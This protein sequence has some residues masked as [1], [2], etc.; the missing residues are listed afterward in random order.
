MSA[1]IRAGETAV[2]AATREAG[3]SLKAAWRAHITGAGLGRQLANTIRSE[4]FP[5]GR[6]RLNAAALVWS[7]APVIVGAHVAGPLIRSRNGYWLAIPTPAAG[8][9]SRGGRI[10]P[11]NGSVARGCGCGSSIG[12]SGRAYWWRKGG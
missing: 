2:C 11:G 4:Q 6:P 5:N 9:T 12:A 1:E 10:T 7:K 8:K 3:N